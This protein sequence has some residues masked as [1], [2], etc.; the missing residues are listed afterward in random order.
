MFLALKQW[1]ARRPVLAMSLLSGTLAGTGDAMAQS[2]ALREKYK[3]EHG[4]PTLVA[5]KDTTAT[6]SSQSQQHG[7]ISHWKRHYDPLRTVR[8]TINA[9]IFAP[10]V[11]R[12]HKFL[13]HALPIPTVNPS[14]PFTQCV[15]HALL[16]LLRRV[17]VDQAV[18]GPLA[19][20]VFFTT[21]TLLE[22]GWINEIKD[23]MSQL[24]LTTYLAGLYV[25]PTAQAIN[26]MFVPLTYRVA[27]SATVSMFWQAYISWVNSSPR[28]AAGVVLSQPAPPPS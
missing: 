2:I 14:T 22:G 27:F 17:A 7:L 5:G 23:K 21:I 9:A 16:P 18:F 4:L 8:F 6:T 1:I 13:H 11:F 25:W 19:N 12:W 24:W 26:F 10:I 15:R 20:T 28:A 3:A